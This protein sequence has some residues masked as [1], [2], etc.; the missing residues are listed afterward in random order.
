MRIENEVAGATVALGEGGHGL[1]GMRERV[2]LY[3]GTFF[4]PVPAR[5]A[6]FRFTPAFR[7]EVVGDGSRW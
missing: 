3:G 1:I 4:A 2:S 6:A 5:A 7:G